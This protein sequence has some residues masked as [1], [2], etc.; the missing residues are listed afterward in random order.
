MKMLQ[1]VFLA[2]CVAFSLAVSAICLILGLMGQG[3][4]IWHP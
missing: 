2:V 4:T 3:L 1:Y